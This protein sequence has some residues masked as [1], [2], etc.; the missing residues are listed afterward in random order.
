MALT[1][2]QVINETHLLIEIFGIRESR[3]VGMCEISEVSTG[4]RKRVE[5]AGTKRHGVSC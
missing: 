4:D 3:S 1:L 2:R 5:F